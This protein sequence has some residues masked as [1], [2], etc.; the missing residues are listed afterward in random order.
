MEHN[1]HH[2]SVCK[3]TKHDW[4]CLTCGGWY[5]HSVPG[6]EWIQWLSYY[7]ELLLPVPVKKICLGVINTKSDK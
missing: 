5:S 4:K 6:D 2:Q 1:T 3:R 7:N